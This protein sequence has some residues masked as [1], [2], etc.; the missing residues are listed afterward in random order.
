MVSYINIY[1]KMFRIF[2]FILFYFIGK[3]FWWLWEWFTCVQKEPLCVSAVGSGSAA[4]GQLLLRCCSSCCFLYHRYWAFFALPTVDPTLFFTQWS[5]RA[6]PITGGWP[7]QCNSHRIPYPR[8]H[9]CWWHSPLLSY[10]HLWSENRCNPWAIKPNLLYCHSP[11]N[12]LWA[13]LRNLWG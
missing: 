3:C 9:H 11:R 7:L 6:L 4:L 8:N 12:P 5:Q 13:A 10:S 2:H 1:S